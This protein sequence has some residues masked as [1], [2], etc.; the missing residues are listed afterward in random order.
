[1]KRDIIEDLH[2]YFEQKENKNGSEVDFLN[3]LT[4]ELPYFQI[5]AISRED[6]AQRG[7]DISGV[8]DE[9]MRE[10][11]RKMEN[12]SLEQLFWS[13][14]EILA[15]NGV[16]IPKYMCPKCGKDA[17]R[18]NSYDKIFECSSCDHSWKLTESTGRYVLVQFPED[19]KFFNDHEIGYDCYD[20]E[21]SGAKYVPE[22]IYIAHFDKEPSESTIF[23]L[24]QWPESQK[25]FELGPES[26][27]ALCEPI[28][29][30]TKL[31][32]D[33]IMPAIWVPLC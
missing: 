29:Y 30:D 12:D 14:M 23:R 7:F 3:R 18:Y 13:S 19:N 4:E 2:Q 32:Q 5:T 28:E 9:D 6:L 8:D 24:V 26:I 22:H 17:G 27:A 10:L 15:K 20:S 31:M 11:A 25:Y 21:D 33:V 16:E 1:M